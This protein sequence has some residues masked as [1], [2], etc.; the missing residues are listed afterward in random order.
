MSNLKDKI[1]KQVEAINNTISSDDER[2]KVLNSVQ[3]ILQDFTSYIVH[4][5]ESQEELQNKVDELTEIVLSLEDEL[6]GE[7]D[8]M[9]ATCP[10]CG[11]EIP[12]L[13]KDADYSSF[14]CPNC[15]NE[16]E[17]E[18]KYDSDDSC[19]YSKYGEPSLLSQKVY[20]D[21][22]IDIG[23]RENGHKKDN[24]T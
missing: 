8:D 4:L 13:F 2:T 20:K 16:I 21:N 19:E 22:V 11:E 12:L 15:H 9:L 5:S 17:L 6:H 1:T 23:F 14:E 24:R 18:F 3:E 7:A 10:Y